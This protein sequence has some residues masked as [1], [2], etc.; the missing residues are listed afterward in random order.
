MNPPPSPNPPPGSSL[1]CPDAP[2]PSASGA[3]APTPSPPSAAPAAP[4]GQTPPQQG[5]QSIPPV[6]PFKTST[7]PTAAAGK[8]TM[9][10][11]Q[12]ERL[13]A[14][15]MTPEDQVAVLTELRDRVI[16]TALATT[17]TEYPAFLENLL[18]IFESLIQTVPVQS[19]EN[20]QHGIRHAII[21][22]LERLLPS[23]T[24]SPHKERLLTLA[25]DVV[26]KDNEENAVL[27][28]K[29]LSNLFKAFRGKLESHV[30]PCFILVLDMYRLLP[31]AVGEAFAPSAASAM[32]EQSKEEGVASSPPS[33]DRLA[34]EGSATG[35]GGGKGGGGSLE[36]S[37]KV[38]TAGMKSFKV[39]VEC[40]FLIMVLS[41]YY[42]NIVQRQSWVAELIGLAVKGL[43]LRPPEEVWK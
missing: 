25:L 2:P 38:L 28:A 18:P 11:A 8:T 37:K 36:K 29:I 22:M 21:D 43:E 13:K 26:R 27:G 5:Q 35:G 24:L 40:P 42:G 12:A 17:V 20:A 41:S 34:S 19:V 23:D 10:E 15:D 6:P 4:A 3:P 16:E 7:T 32:E 14:A 1:P 30:Q 9:W 31:E 39:L 33:L